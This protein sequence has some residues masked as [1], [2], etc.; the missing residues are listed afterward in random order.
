[1]CFSESARK[2]SAAVEDFSLENAHQ[3]AA[4][5]A[6]AAAHA[7]SFKRFERGRGDSSLPGG[8]GFETTF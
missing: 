8:A 2:L 3:H 6:M 5:S 1:M 7:T 4:T